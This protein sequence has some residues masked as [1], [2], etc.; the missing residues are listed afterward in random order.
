[1]IIS[2]YLDNIE[3][4]VLEKSQSTNIFLVGTVRDWNLE[5]Y[6]WCTFKKIALLKYRLKFPQE[7]CFSTLSLLV[8]F[9]TIITRFFK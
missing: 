9:I 1:M 2:G 3:G 7:I 4:V 8:I 6:T 5:E